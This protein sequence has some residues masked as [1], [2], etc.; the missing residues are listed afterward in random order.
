MAHEIVHMWFGNLVTMNW[1]E[2]LWLNES[3]ATVMSYY[4]VNE[5]FPEWNAWNKFMVYEYS[6]ALN[7]DALRSTHSIQMPIKAKHDIGQNFDTISYEKGGSVL[8]MIKGYLGDDIFMA[9]LQLYISRHAY[10]NAKTK[11]LWQA[12][13]DASGKPVRK[14]M[15][16]WISQPGYPLLEISEK[17]E[18]EVVVRQHR[19]LSSGEPLQEEEDNQIWLIETNYI[20][21]EKKIEA[22]KLEKKEEIVSI[23][24]LA[25]TVMAP[26]SSTVAPIQ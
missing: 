13:E 8:R 12:L 17:N 1:W 10:G 26:S 18:N 14:I 6:S 24:S 19:F 23:N 16:S 9:G 7:D 4:F 25:G 15:E 22:I 11:D 20:N 2:E 21:S 5:L 3:F